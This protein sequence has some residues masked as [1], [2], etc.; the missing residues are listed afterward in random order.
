M[1]FTVQHK[2][3]PRAKWKPSRFDRPH[4][5]LEAAVRH[6]RSFDQDGLLHPGVI[7]IVDGFGN[8]VPPATYAG[9]AMEAH[10]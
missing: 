8:V 3:S 1:A 4:E 9:M 2:D 5:T 10:V 6:A 7:R